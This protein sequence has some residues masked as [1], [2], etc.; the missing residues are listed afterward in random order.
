VALGL[1]RAEHDGL[2]LRI[3]DIKLDK[4]IECLISRRL[5]VTQGAK[6]TR[7]LDQCSQPLI[8]QL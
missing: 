5:A 2:L 7:G 4:I 6:A 1:V 8:E 3:Q